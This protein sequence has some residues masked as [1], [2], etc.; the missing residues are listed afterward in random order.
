[1]A[2]QIRPI[3]GNPVQ[4][5]VVCFGNS[6]SAA[7]EAPMKMYSFSPADIA[8]LPD[9]RTRRILARKA[10]AVFFGLGST[11]SLKTYDAFSLKEAETMLNGLAQRISGLGFQYE[12]RDPTDKEPNAVFLVDY[13]TFEEVTDPP[14]MP[15]D[16]PA[17][18]LTD[19]EE[20]DF[21]MPE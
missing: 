7:E 10:C 18:P 1:M 16:A 5:V 3:L 19:K 20:L 21:D 6:R 9:P 8:A 14:T 12:P 17:A 13:C 15:D 2:P 4:I 11:R